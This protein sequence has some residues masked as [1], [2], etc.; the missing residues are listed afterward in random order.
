[1]EITAYVSDTIRDPKFFYYI[2]RIPD[3]IQRSA[4]LDWFT[5]RDRPVL[6]VDSELVGSP[7]LRIQGNS[8][9]LKYIRQEYAVLLHKSGGQASDS[10]VPSTEDHMVYGVMTDP[11]TDG[12][13]ILCKLQE[14]GS[15][16][17][18]RMWEQFYIDTG[19]IQNYTGPHMKTDVGKFLVNQLLLVYPFGDLIPYMNTR[20]DPGKLD[21][22][23][24]DLILER[25][26]DRTMYNRYMSA[27]Y[28]FGTDGSLAI[29][30]WTDKSLGT[31]PRIA[32][33]KK[34]LLEAN[35]DKMDDPVV[36][37]Q[38]EKELMDMDKAY[39]RGDASEPFYFANEKASFQDQRKKMFIGIGLM[40]KFSKGA[41]GFEY[42]DPSLEEG[43][44]I[45]DVMTCSNEIRR[46]AYGRAIGT[47]KGGEQT[48]F[49]MR[50]F[51][52]T[53]ITEED[54][55]TKH[56]LPVTITEIN[57]K[58]FINRWTVDGKLIT[59]DNSAE[60]IGQSITL[61]S[62]MYCQSK[63]GYCSRC[64]GEL[65]KRIEMPNFG[66]NT[67]MV[68]AKM[69]TAS[70][71]SMHQSTISFKNITDINRF[72]Y[73]STK[74]AIVAANSDEV[75]ISDAELLAHAQ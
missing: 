7:I 55:G 57:H 33:R 61:R 67:L 59:S 74:N 2:S 11:S 21:Q 29:T 65:F 18:F 64:L 5:V 73:K 34:E 32:Q 12:I 43:W 37:A 27:G 52:E 54:C 3:C 46:G 13:V 70:M 10:P 45:Q 75:E 17:P 72:L 42:V 58:E 16:P 40:P 1:M 20:I 36:L 53:H 6:A 62:P 51:Q 15:Q 26:V 44:R 68:G 8:A 66:V 19:M 25:K 41:G 31:D 47:A 30:S 48:K 56:G 9:E 24:A 63:S 69:T 23:V 38:M 71:R 14:D 60:F 22:K 4:L 35:K 28:W 39:I 50:I 49:I